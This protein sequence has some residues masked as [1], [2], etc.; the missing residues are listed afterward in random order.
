MPSVNSVSN[1]RPFD[2]STVITPSLPTFSMTSPIR[3]PISLSAA[4]MEATWAISSLPLTSVDISLM[5]ATTASAARS[6]PCLRSM[7]LAPA[8]T[9]RMPSWTMAWARTVAVVVPSPAT[10]LVLVAASFR[11]WA[12]MLANGSSSSISLATVTPSWVTVGAP[13]FLSRA[14]LR[15]FGPRVV[16]TA[17]ARTSTPS[18]K[19]RRAV[20]LNSRTFGMWLISLSLLGQCRRQLERVADDASIELFRDDGED[21]LLG[22]NKQVLVVDLE[23]GSR[24]LGEE[25]LVADRNVHRDAISVV[26]TATFTGG[27]DLAALRLLLRRVRQHDAALG[28]LFP[29]CRAHHQPIAEWLQ[30]RG[31]RCC[32]IRHGCSNPPL[33]TSVIDARTVHAPFYSW[34]RQPDGHRFLTRC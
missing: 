24:V 13:N 15:P 28:H 19:E 9:L 31:N 30:L 27:D 11:S 17:L 20:S 12:P 5:R 4:E 14:T 26:V 16:L 32:S 7:A 3:A 10:S 34:R 18:F 21:V 33:G 2:S 8:A 6:R 25:H 29:A 23:L 1:S 22:E